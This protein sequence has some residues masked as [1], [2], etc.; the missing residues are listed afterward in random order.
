MAGAHGPREEMMPTA[1][2]EMKLSHLGN[3]T[4][5]REKLL[6]TFKNHVEKQPDKLLY[7]WIEGNGSVKQEITYSEAWG[8]AERIAQNLMS[9]KGIKRGDRVVMCY[10][11]SLD[12]IQAFIG[13]MIAGLVAVPI[14]PPNPSRLEY[15]I[16]KM[17]YVIE[18]SNA[19]LALSHKEFTKNIWKLKLKLRKSK[20]PSINFINTDK[21]R[22]EKVCETINEIKDEFVQPSVQLPQL[23]FLQYTSGST[24]DPKGVMISYSNLL[25]NLHLLKKS[26][27]RK[28]HHG[29]RQIHPPHNTCCWLPQYHDLGLI[30]NYL[31]VFFSGGRGY[32][33]K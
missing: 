17:T 7:A 31:L 19:K 11:F 30:A 29:K 24:G 9:I 25:H 5:D 20:W 32:L 2:S 21:I 6:N 18:N 15:S 28:R 16:Q 3:I 12:F 22:G 10:A 4:G 27:D 1:E 33:I 13:C 23:A 14:Y 26:G 8:H